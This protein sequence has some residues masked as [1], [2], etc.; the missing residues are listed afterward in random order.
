VPDTARIDVYGF[1]AITE[2]RELMRY[3]TTGVRNRPT[4][5]MNDCRTIS[6]HQHRLV[7][8]VRTGNINAG[9]EFTAWWRRFTPGDSFN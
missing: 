6:N 8:I 2:L 3:R 9:N 1:K 4:C 5:E 7:A